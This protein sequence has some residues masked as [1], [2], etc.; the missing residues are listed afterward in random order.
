MNANKIDTILEQIES[1]SISEKEQLTGGFFTFDVTD[2]PTED[3]NYVQCG[4]NNYQC[5]KTKET[6]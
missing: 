2:V 5:G 1:L 3:N 6:K 4:C